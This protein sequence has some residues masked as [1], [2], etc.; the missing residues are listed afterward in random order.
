MCVS[1][2]DII[3]DDEF[4]LLYDAYSPRTNSPL[5]ASVIPNYGFFKQDLDLLH[6]CLGVP[7]EKNKKKQKN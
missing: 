2:C 3:D 7:E 6:G 1:V 4:V 5:S